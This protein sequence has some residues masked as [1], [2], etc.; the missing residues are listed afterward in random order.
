MLKRVVI[1][2]A[3]TA[4]LAVPAAA[5]AAVQL[6]IH[7][8]RVWLTADHAT[9]ADILAEWSRVGATEMINAERIR[10]PLLTLDLR[11]VPELDAL[12]VIMRSAGGFVAVSRTVGVDASHL[13]RFSRVV[14][15]P[16]AAGGG[17]AM[18][19]PPPLPAPV[20]APPIPTQAPVVTDSGAQRLIGPD[21]QLIPDDQEDA[22]SPPKPAPPATVRPGGSM[23]PG[24]SEP[25]GAPSPNGT[26]RPGV[27]L[28]PTPPRRP[29]AI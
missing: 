6:A 19:V 3:L 17:G 20:Y 18:P 13:S 25:P 24:F 23:P 11:G 15:V 21:G 16:A 28:P 29:G 14:I 7:D 10:S 5:S 12:D 2:W 26:T 4:V 22:P 8:G 1:G 27:I 9:I